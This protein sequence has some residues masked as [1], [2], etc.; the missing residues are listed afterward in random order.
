MWITLQI[1][2]R[3]AYTQNFQQHLPSVWYFSLE[4]QTAC[5][6]LKYSITPSSLML[7]NYAGHFTEPVNLVYLHS[8][9]GHLAKFYVWQH[10]V[11]SL[12]SLYNLLKHELKAFPW[13]FF[14]LMELDTRPILLT[15]NVIFK[16]LFN[17]SLISL[18]SNQCL[19]RIYGCFI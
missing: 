5:R 6:F 16:Q 19:G 4:R 9:K 12:M 14:T 17:Q 1:L 7:S 2:S 3:F 11:L 18:N 13:F 15:C 8:F 10:K